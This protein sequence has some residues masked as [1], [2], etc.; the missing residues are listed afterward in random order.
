M[1]VGGGAGP[2]QGAALGSTSHRASQ[3]NVPRPPLAQEVTVVP[4]P[5]GTRVITISPTITAG[6]L[7]A[8]SIGRVSGV[9]CWAVAASHTPAYTEYPVELV[10]GLMYVRKVPGWQVIDSGTFS[11]VHG[12]VAHH[13]IDLRGTAHPVTV[14][15]Y[16]V[17]ASMTSI[18]VLT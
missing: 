3:I 2:V 13:Q 12:S 1:P 17:D 9:V 16:S 15:I 5:L 8:C 10:N 7:S 11:G 14:F 18:H 4:L 6:A